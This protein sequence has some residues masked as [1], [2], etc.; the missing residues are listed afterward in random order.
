MLFVRYRG[1]PEMTEAL[2]P[3]R[4]RTSVLLLAAFLARDVWER[5]WCEGLGGT[6]VSV[7]LAAVSP[8]M[9]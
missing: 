3:F 8:S 6:Y 7:A 2:D 4:F 9:A 5:Q 1:C